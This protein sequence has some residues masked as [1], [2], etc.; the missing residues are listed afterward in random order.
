M[1]KTKVRSNKITSENARFTRDSDRMHVPASFAF[2]NQTPPAPLALK[3]AESTNF[4][5]MVMRTIFWH[6]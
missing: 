2:H 1:Q 6:T 5:K 3:A 4:H